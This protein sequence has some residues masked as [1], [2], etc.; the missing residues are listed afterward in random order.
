MLRSP[1][2]ADGDYD[3]EMVNSALAVLHDKVGIEGRIVPAPSAHGPSPY[4]DGCLELQVQ[5]SPR[6]Y[7]FEYKRHLD[8]KE[9]ARAVQRGLQS[10]QRPG[11]LITPHLSKQL[12]EYCREID[13]QFIDASGN[14]YLRDANLFIYIAGQ[15]RDEG[16]PSA[17]PLRSLGAAALRVHFVLLVKPSTIT[18]PYR[19]IAEQAGVSLGAVSGVMDDLKSRGLLFDPGPRERRRLAQP[20]RLFQEWVVAYPVVLR[21]KLR[22]TRFSSPDPHWWQQHTA[23]PQG[24]MWGGEVA[25]QILTDYLKPAS[26]TL[27]VGPTQIHEVVRDLVVK[28]RWRADPAGQIEVLEKFWTFE[29]DPVQAQIVPPILIYADL[30]G[31][32]DSRNMETAKLI[33]DQYIDNPPSPA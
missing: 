16:N 5:G 10:H 1:Q 30:L 7:L 2:N 22:P 18:L 4:P 24:A 9:A 27:Y 8:R 13:L 14:A 19:D 29:P 31:S 12:A 28:H 33:K 15:K 20:E 21:P 23:L 32:L 26:Q 25:A 6:R 17:K 3:R 11:L